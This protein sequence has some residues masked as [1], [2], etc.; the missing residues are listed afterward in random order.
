MS[1]LASA[2]VQ[3]ALQELRAGG[4][5]ED[6][7]YRERVS[8]RERKLGS[9]LSPGDRAAL[10]VDAPLAISA[11]VG[12]VLHALALT[13]RPSLIVEFGASLGIST[14]Y[15]AC[16]LAD[17][18]AGRLITTELIPG[19]AKRTESV[20]AGAGLGRY[21]EVRAGDAR[22]TLDGIDRQVDLLFLDGAND[23]Y[24]AILELLTPRLSA[25]AVIA[26]DMSFGDRNHDRYR[27]HVNDPAGGL[28]A[29]ELRLDAG[30]VI[31]TPR[32]ADQRTLQDMQGA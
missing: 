17:L 32:S 4:E 15:L 21:V 7:L 14:I 19:K 29:T 9:T 28:V 13:A 24:L 6:Q 23:L 1:V 18:G 10:A 26:A 31:A 8:A 3:R 16:A 20:I 22:E 30:L 27:A 2:Q 25:T 11:E 5:R 12:G